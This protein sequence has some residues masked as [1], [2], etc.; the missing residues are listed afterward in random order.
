[1]NIIC[2]DKSPL[3]LRA[4]LRHTRKLMPEAAVRGCRD[5]EEAEALARAEGCDVLLT[6]TDLRRLHL[7]GF[8]LAERIRAIN[9][10][11]NIIFVSDRESK[12]EADAA[13]RLRA[14]GYV[15]RPYEQKQLAE[16]FANLRY[17]A[18]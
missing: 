16:E 3:A 9:P 8:M 14:S 11:V 7:T 17:A 2:V 5:P 18:V 6:G 10:R 12:A 15:V 13:L 4:L 1:M